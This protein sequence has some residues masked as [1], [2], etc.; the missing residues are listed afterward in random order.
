MKINELIE[1]REQIELYWLLKSTNLKLFHQTYLQLVEL[2]G[3]ATILQQQNIRSELVQ[4]YSYLDILLR[5]SDWQNLESV[6]DF[7]I[8]YDELLDVHD[9]INQFLINTQSQSKY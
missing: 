1:S 7:T 3:G 8:V 6:P 5:N 9:N 4:V 2:Y